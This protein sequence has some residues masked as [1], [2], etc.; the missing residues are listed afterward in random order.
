VTAVYARDTT[1][2][3]LFSDREALVEQ[4]RLLEERLAFYEGFDL[5]IQ[6]NVAQARELF[7]LAA[8]ERAAA[9]KAANRQSSRAA[10]RELVL[11]GELEAIAAELEALSRMVDALSRRVA[12]ALGEPG[13]VPAD[14]WPLSAA[15]PVERAM[16]VVVHGVPSARIALSLQ[17]FVA[18]L[19]QVREVFA[20]EFAGG[21]LRL[22]AQV[23]DRLRVEQFRHW[24][25]APGIQPLTEGPDVIEFALDGQ[26]TVA[27][28][29][30]A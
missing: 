21:V 6:D 7:R 9:G 8:Q 3:A 30:R 22:D 17:R 4:I 1:D 10:E 24:E 26:E 18:S 5:Q 25:H 15:A 11:R 14:G 27:V 19:P 13:G 2:D 29:L 23:Q 28:R 12:Q 16:A 20:R